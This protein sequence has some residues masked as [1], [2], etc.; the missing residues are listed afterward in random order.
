MKMVRD[1]DDEAKT[2]WF[3]MYIYNLADD[4]KVW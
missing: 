1:N 4:R 3:K 2:K